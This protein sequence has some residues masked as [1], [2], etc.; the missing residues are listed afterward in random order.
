MQICIMR[1]VAVAGHLKQG[2]TSVSIE[3]IQTSPVVTRRVWV[4]G[5][6]Q[7]DIVKANPQISTEKAQAIAT[8][9]VD[10]LSDYHVDRIINSI[11]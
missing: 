11:H 3:T 2:D 8:A 9:R 4:R 1:G 5:I 7:S 6:I 10:N